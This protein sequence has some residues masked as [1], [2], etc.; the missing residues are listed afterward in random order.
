MNRSQFR[1]AVHAQVEI[2]LDRTPIV[3]SPL[4]STD[5]F[6][7]AKEALLE[8]LD[9]RAGIRLLALLQDQGYT[10]TQVAR[11]LLAAC[12]MMTCVSGVN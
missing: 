9:R 1:D 8:T 12:E 6:R 3:S 5:T 2:E 11:G 7:A 10:P 4:V